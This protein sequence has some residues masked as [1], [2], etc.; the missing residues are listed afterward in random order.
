[1]GVLGRGWIEMGLVVV[2]K[3][4]LAKIV[5]VGQLGCGGLV[6]VVVD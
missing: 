4:E 1:M 2:E 5:A 3:R 6:M